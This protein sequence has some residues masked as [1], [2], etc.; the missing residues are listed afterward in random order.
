MEGDRKKHRS[1]L[2]IRVS[3]WSVLLYPQCYITSCEAALLLFP[4][5]TST[6]LSLSSRQSV[7]P[8]F[9][10][11][12]VEMMFF[13]YVFSHFFHLTFLFLFFF[14]LVWWKEST[15]ISMLAIERE[16]PLTVPTLSPHLWISDFSSSFSFFFTLPCHDCYARESGLASRV[17][18]QSMKRYDQTIRRSCWACPVWPGRPYLDQKSTVPIPQLSQG[19]DA[20]AWDEDRRS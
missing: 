15:T 18:P 9:R 5:T 7:R 10:L 8:S 1:D 19:W 4:A 20:V 12:T 2:G 17:D 6:P 3:S 16:S 13:F 11:P 14:F